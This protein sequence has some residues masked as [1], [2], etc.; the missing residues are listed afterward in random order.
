MCHRSLQT[1]YI[2][3]YLFCVC[4]STCYRYSPLFSSYSKRQV[5][6]EK[7]QKFIFFDVLIWYAV[8]PSIQL[9]HPKL[10]KRCPQMF[11]EFKSIHTLLLMAW[12]FLDTF[13]VNETL[14]F[15]T[16]CP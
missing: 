2:Y 15:E 8:I 5:I 3:T 6:L 7:M 1:T 16:F 10:R 9:Q 14:H 13:F 12:P 11:K 4:R